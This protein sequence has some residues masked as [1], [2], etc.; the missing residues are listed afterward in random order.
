MLEYNLLNRGDFWNLKKKRVVRESWQ[1]ERYWFY[2]YNGKI[3]CFAICSSW[4]YYVVF[5]LI[6]FLSDD[7]SFLGA[8]VWTFFL[9]QK[10]HLQL[11]FSS[12]L[13]FPLALQALKATMLTSSLPNHITTP[14]DGFQFFFFL[15]HPIHSVQQLSISSWICSRA[16]LSLK[17][18][19]YQST[20]TSSYGDYQ[21]QNLFNTDWTVEGE[22]STQKRA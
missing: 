1:L 16:D 7:I 15:F 3:S 11:F 17:I 4:R 21:K 6:E 9:T 8:S 20:L 2:L 13:S 5:R 12:L 14:R 18:R 22:N 10:V 19:L